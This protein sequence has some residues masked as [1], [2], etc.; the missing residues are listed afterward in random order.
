M[1]EKSDNGSRLTAAISDFILAAIDHITSSVSNLSNGRFES[2]DI[3]YSVFLAG[4]HV[5]KKRD[6]NMQR[7]KGQ[8]RNSS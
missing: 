4:S 6:N 7:K 3:T 5:L 2:M 8:G 1:I